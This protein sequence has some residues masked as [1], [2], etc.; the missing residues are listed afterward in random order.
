MSREFAREGRRGAVRADGAVD[1]DGAAPVPGRRTAATE[2]AAHLHH[3]V[4][5]HYV[6]GLV[7]ASINQAGT[8]IVGRIAITRGTRSGGRQIIGCH[9]HAEL[10]WTNEGSTGF[11]GTSTRDRSRREEAVTLVVSGS[12]Q[13]RIEIAFEGGMETV[14]DGAGDLLIPMV[15][16]EAFELTRRSADPALSDATVA[17]AAPLDRTSEATPLDGASEARVR[18]LVGELRAACAVFFDGTASLRMSALSRMDVATEAAYARVAPSQHTLFT[19]TVREALLAAGWYFHRVG[20]HGLDWLTT[21]L[22]RAKTDAGRVTAERLGIPFGEGAREGS[23]PHTYRI[24][25]ME[26]ASSVGPVGPR[27]GA[28]HVEELAGPGCERPWSRTYPMAGGSLDVGFVSDVGGSLGEVAQ[29]TVTVADHW[30]PEDFIGEV[31]GMEAFL[32]VRWSAG[33]EGG[34]PHAEDGVLV[35][36]GTRVFEPIRLDLETLDAGAEAEGGAGVTVRYEQVLGRLSGEMRTAETTT[37]HREPV[38]VPAQ[39]DIPVAFDTDEM[40]LTPAGERALR[41]VVAWNL[42]LLRDPEVYVVVDGYASRL[43]SDAHNV[44]LSRGRR[45]SVIAELSSAVPAISSRV[46]EGEARGEAAAREAGVR[47]EDDD[48]QQWRRADVTI[49]G[50]L[51]L[52]LYAPLEGR[53][54]ASHAMVRGSARD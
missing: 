49:D 14:S 30:T 52:R 37:A 51:V 13:L 27:G 10:A 48:A 12:G 33:P 21:A 53:P 24:T 16:R 22:Q 26:A 7:T 8:T 18:N 4:T 44:L 39:V 19:A 6:G 38:R 32:G 29:T 28:L 11:R 50:T 5:G 3:E 43:G 46:L 23:V 54:D 41:Q 36:Y 20:R 40:T 35:L 2:P 42:A 17:A 47:R 31:S 9:Y 15:R 45:Q 34:G 1:H 25:L